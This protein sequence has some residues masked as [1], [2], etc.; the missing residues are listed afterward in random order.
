MATTITQP[1]AVLQPWK[2]LR[3]AV[4]LAVVMAVGIGAGFLL[5]GNSRQAVQADGE[6]AA[7]LRLQELAHSLVVTP[8]AGPIDTRGAT[9]D[10]S[11]GGIV[12]GVFPVENLNWTP[13][14]YRHP[15]AVD[16]AEH[17]GFTPME[18]RHPSA[19]TERFG[20]LDADLD[21]DVEA[22]DVRGFIKAS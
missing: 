6:S 22:V 18:Y 16:T 3:Q 15:A 4:I 8:Q 12:Y 14:E 2:I 5:D 9:Y 10:P 21:P 13:F 19:I 1:A 7:S 11:F 20:G 17:G